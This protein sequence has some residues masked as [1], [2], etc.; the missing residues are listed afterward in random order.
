M[1]PDGVVILAILDAALVALFFLFRVLPWSEPGPWRLIWITAS[2]AAM[3]FSLGE[4]QAMIKGGDALAFEVQGPLFGAILAMTACFILVYM[5]G[6]RIG[7]R[8]IALALTDDLTQLPNSRSFSETLAAQLRQPEPFSLAYIRLDGLGVVNDVLGPSRGDALLKGFADLL[9]ARTSNGDRAARL[10]GDRFALILSGDDARASE[11][12]K[13][14]QES[15]REMT[16]RDLAGIDVVTHIGIVGRDQASDP[17]R[18]L[19]LA[20]RK[21]QDAR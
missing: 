20:Y 2:L 6:A 19:H 8:A 5:H 17:G 9:R 15:F 16:F 11:E 10:S 1:S 18:L 14:I 7:S 3:L 13:K 21:T 4:L 12:S